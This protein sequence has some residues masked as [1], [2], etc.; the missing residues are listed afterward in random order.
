M[1]DN[2]S[3]DDVLKACPKCGNKRLVVASTLLGDGLYVICH[4]CHAQ[5]AAVPTRKEAIEFWN[6]GI[7][8]E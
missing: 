4:K 3:R 7:L 6:K 5:T 1:S 2:A 8:E